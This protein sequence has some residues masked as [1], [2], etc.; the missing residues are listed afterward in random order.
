MD[1]ICNKFL[2]SVGHDVHDEVGF[3]DREREGSPEG[4][5]RLRTQQGCH[6]PQSCVTFAFVG[7]LS[8]ENIKNY[9]TTR[10]Y[11]GE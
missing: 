4:N 11:K 7:P 1:N 6:S 2:P 3:G 10:L 8:M 5:C 9:L